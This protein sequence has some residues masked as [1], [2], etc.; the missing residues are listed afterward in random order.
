MSVSLDRLARVLT[1]DQRL[2]LAAVPSLEELN[3]AC[4]GLR[5]FSAP[6]PDGL[7]PAFYKHFWD[8]IGPILLAL[9]IDARGGGSLP[10]D[11]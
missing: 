9:L 4:L 6:G 2:H 8:F 10:V 7:T 1:P 5:S 3:R 11:S